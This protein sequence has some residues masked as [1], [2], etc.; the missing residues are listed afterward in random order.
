MGQER[1]LFQPASLDP[2]TALATEPDVN[3]RMVDVPGARLSM[4]GRLP[5]VSMG[6]GGVPVSPREASRWAM[7]SLKEASGILGTE[8][9][10]GRTERS[11][12]GMFGIGGTG[13]LGISRRCL[14]T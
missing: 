7:R 8:G 6:G 9:T 4:L 10:L 3:E 5:R 2:I 13:S 12:S 14:G 11:A 1:L